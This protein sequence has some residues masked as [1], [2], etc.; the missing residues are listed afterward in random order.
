MLTQK[1]F[2][3]SEN[4]CALVRVCLVTF[5]VAVNIYRQ[6]LVDICTRSRVLGETSDFITLTAMLRSTIRILSVNK[7]RIP[8][9]RSIIGVSRK[10]QD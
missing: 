2:L 3:L 4:L 8:L 10:R 9:T 1:H 7:N 5:V 6:N